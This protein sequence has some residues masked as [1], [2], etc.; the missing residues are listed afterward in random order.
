MRTVNSSHLA[1]GPG[2]NLI[3][4]FTDTAATT[5]DIVNTGSLGKW[6]IDVKR[7]DATWNNNLKLYVKRISDG[8]G[9][10]TVSGGLSL[11]EI[12]GSDSPFFTGIGDRSGL[13]LSYELSGMS[14]AVAPNMYSTSV[15]F[16]A[17][18]TP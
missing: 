10:G 12:T 8:S 6:R 18:S 11:I 13:A 9:G 1:T 15:S 14:V 16:V 3:A 4:T 7:T 17:V 2:S 5:L